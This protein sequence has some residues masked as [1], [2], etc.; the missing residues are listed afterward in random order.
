MPNPAVTWYMSPVFLAAAGAF[1]AIGLLML[2]SIYFIL[3]R[4]KPRSGSFSQ[5]ED[6]MTCSY[7]ACRFRFK[8]IE[9][10]KDQ[11]DRDYQ[12][13]LDRLLDLERKAK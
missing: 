9:N 3:T 1:F 13:V 7:E 6:E 2:V 11:H 10:W 8:A 5:F 4:M 12:R